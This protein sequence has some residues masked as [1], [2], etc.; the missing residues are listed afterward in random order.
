MKDQSYTTT[1]TIA[2]S[3]KDVFDHLKNVPTWWSGED[4]K[5]NSAK[6]HDEFTIMHG[7]AHYSKQKLVEVIPERKIV[8]LVTESR[9]T[10]LER[11]QDEW[12]NTKMVFEIIPKGDLTELHFTH[13]GLVPDKACYSRCTQGWDMVIKVA[14]AKAMGS[15]VRLT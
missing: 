3:P 8:W 5:G 11:D 13:E 9:L 10:W 2:R 7:D 6:L 12:T 14:F 1:I 4:F 15:G